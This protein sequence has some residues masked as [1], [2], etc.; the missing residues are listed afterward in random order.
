MAL[1][2]HTGYQVPRRLVRG[3][4]PT[5]ACRV[6][7][8][9]QNSQPQ[10]ESDNLPF[11]SQYD[12]RR[13]QLLKEVTDKA[14]KYKV[15][16]VAKNATVFKGLCVLGKLHKRVKLGI[17]IEIEK[18]KIDDDTDSRILCNRVTL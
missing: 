1:V 12:V 13:V 3:T 4:H 10:K 16:K 7:K 14:R 2:L 11:F 6:A 8:N 18:A 17:S 9:A 15:M 5:L